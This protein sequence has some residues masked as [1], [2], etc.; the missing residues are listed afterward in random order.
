MFYDV[1]ANN[2]IYACFVGERLNEGRVFAFEP[3]PA[4]ADHCRSNLDRNGIDGSVY[5]VALAATSGTAELT[6]SDQ[7]AGAGTHSLGGED[8]RS[9]IRV[10]TRRGDE[11]IVEESVPAPTVMK[12]D[13]EG[14]ELDVI[15]GFEDTLRDDS[16]GTL[17]CEVHRQGIQQFGH[18]AG[19]VQ[20]LLEDWGFAVQRLRDRGDQFFLCAS[21]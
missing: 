8:G 5:E 16:F 7:G 2:G 10:D 4:N 13:V 21:K 14:A 11:F 19:D 20:E 15:R 18:A 9:S 12:I 6:V 3:H 17:Y 1:G